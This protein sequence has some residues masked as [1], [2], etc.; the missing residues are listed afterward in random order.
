[1]ARL[2][3]WRIPSAEGRSDENVSA[4]GRVV[5]GYPQEDHTHGGPQGGPQEEDH[6]EDHKEVRR[7]LEEDHKEDSEDSCVKKEDS[8]AQKGTPEGFPRGMTPAQKKED[9]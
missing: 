3:S 2:A 9:S 7:T 5:G 1:M 4:P 6:K 8:Q